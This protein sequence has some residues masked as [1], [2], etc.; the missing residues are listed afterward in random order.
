MSSWRFELDRDGVRELMQSPEMVKCIKDFAY[1]AKRQAGDGYKVKS[2]LTATRAM[3]SVFA[4]SSKAN[5]DNLKQNTLLK[6]I[7]SVK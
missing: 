2:K 1:D 7:G 3:S 4:Y 6:A 5:S